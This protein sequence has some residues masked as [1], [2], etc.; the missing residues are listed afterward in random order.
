MQQASEFVSAGCLHINLQSCMIILSIIV[1]YH[2]MSSSLLI[3][4][5]LHLANIT[6]VILLKLNSTDLYDC[7]I[8]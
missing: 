3:H 8:C 7:L 5:Y 6:Y 2:V 1:Y 4:V